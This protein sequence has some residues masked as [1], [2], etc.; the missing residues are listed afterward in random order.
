MEIDVSSLEVVGEEVKGIMSMDL[1]SKALGMTHSSESMAPQFP[2]IPFRSLDKGCCFG[3]GD[4]SLVGSHHPV[5]ADWSMI[6]GEPGTLGWG[7]E[8]TILCRP[9]QVHEVNP[10]EFLH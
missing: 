5:D 8:V 9:I 1:R 6:E 3:G 7:K 4:L 10:H 2:S